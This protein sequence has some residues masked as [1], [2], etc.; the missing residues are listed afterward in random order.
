MRKAPAVLPWT[1]LLL[2][3]AALCGCACESQTVRL[4]PVWSA[5]VPEYGVEY[6]KTTN[7]FPLYSK[8]VTVYNDRIEETGN[9]MLLFSW[10]K[11]TM[12]T[13]GGPAAEAVPIEAVLEEPAVEAAIAPEEAAE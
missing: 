8:N 9:S 7:V 1:T 3:V 4:N 13:G 6:S 2:G 10:S 12:R 11:T 5:T